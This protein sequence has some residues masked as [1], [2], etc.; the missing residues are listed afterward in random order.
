MIT[1]HINEVINNIPQQPQVQYSLRDQ[2]EQLR[3]AANK[4][5]LYDAAD[6][7]KFDKK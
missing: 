4:L 7:L 3:L 1:N 2:L 5:G 6:Y